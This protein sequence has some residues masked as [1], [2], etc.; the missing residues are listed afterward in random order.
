MVGECSRFGEQLG[1]HVGIGSRKR[2]RFGQLKTLSTLVDWKGNEHCFPIICTAGKGGRWR[3]AIDA[4]KA[5]GC[6]RQVC[7]CYR[8]AQYFYSAKRVLWWLSPAC[9]AKTA[10]CACAVMLDKKWVVLGQ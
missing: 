8:C 6:L 4:F 2:Q 9:K 5:L 10:L 7:Y 3:Q 1:L